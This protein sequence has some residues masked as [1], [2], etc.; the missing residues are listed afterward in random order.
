MRFWADIV[1]QRPELVDELP[2][3][4]TPLLWGY[5]AEHPFEEQTRVL[6]QAGRPYYV[7]PGTSSWQSFAG[8][9]TNARA[10]LASAARQGHARGA[11]GYLITDWGDRGHHQPLPVS[12]PGFLVGAGHAWSAATAERTLADGFV[13]ALLDRHVFRDPA[14]RTGAWLLR[15]GDAYR[16]CGARSSNGSPLFFVFSFAHEP[17][18]PERVEG[19]ATEPLRDLE[20]ALEQD[21][22]AA[23]PARPEALGGP[24]VIRELELLGDLVAWSSRFARARLGA[25]AGSSLDALPR[26]AAAELKQRLEDLAARHRDLWLARSR[27]GGLDASCR[28]FQRLL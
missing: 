25:G 22:A 24:L 13:A 12:L 18:P 20:R 11:Q 1:L 10:N 8:R 19:L 16:R 21:R 5:D 28:W 6:A 14:R 23:A 17:F 3:D 2:E 4:I 7:C 26:E 15:L 9:W 27:P